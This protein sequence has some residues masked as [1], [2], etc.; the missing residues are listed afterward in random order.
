MRPD[1]LMAAAV[2]AELLGA[3][4]TAHDGPAT[5]P[6]R[7]DWLLEGHGKRY[8]VEVT[9]CND[10][11]RRRFD[12]R[13]EKE[14]GIYRKVEGLAGTY[15]VR[16]STSSAPSALW[17][18]LPE[19]IRDHFPDGVDFQALSRIRWDRAHPLQVPAQKLSDA[20]VLW[21]NGQRVEGR[22]EMQITAEAAWWEHP[23]AVEEAAMTQ[24]DGNRSK[25]AAAEDVDERH[26]FVWIH[27]SAMQAHYSMRNSEGLPPG[28]PDLGPGIDVL[29]VASSDMNRRP[30]AVWK[31]WRVES[32]RSWENWTPSVRSD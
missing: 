4:A 2:L 30:P 19:L 27:P 8:A 13:T 32:N 21:I 6:G 26:L 12:V 3:K 10:E 1:E 7:F 28:T 17:K 25:L 11:S 22:S 9:S 16:V 14:G 23:A 18:V 24:L 31:L 29:W 5:G 15:L 20:G